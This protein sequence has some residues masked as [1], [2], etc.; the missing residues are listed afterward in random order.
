M[1]SFATLLDGFRRFRAGEY[2]DQRR[3]FDALAL[4]GQSP[5]LMIIACSDSRVD[6][7]RVFDV[8]PGQVFVVR[9]VA[10]L[11]PPYEAAVGYHSTSAAIEFGVT[12]LEVEYIVVLGHAQCGGINAALT[13]K[14]DGAAPGEGGFI[15]HWMDMIAPARDATRAAAAANPDVDAQQLLELAAIR[16]SLANLRSF[17]FIAS[18]LAAGTLH[19]RGTYFGIADGIL[20]VLDEASGRFEAVAVD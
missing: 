4:H 10:N 8:D 16:L 17:P 15:G 9:N 3:R 6:P 14:F 5:R 13:G 19:L 11:V 20:R 2:Q 7:T 12:Q 1:P 18:R